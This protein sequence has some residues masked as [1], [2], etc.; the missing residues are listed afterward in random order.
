MIAELQKKAQHLLSENASAILTA[1]G[2]V[3]TVGTA[4]LTGRAS[5]KAAEI[6]HLEELDRVVEAEKVTEDDK[7]IE[8]QRLSKTEKVGL[9]WPQFLPPVGLGVATIASI[10]MANRISATRA[11]ALAAAYGV[12]Q[13]QLEEYKTKALE[14]LGVNKEQKLRDELAQDRVNENP[15]NKE[16]IIL[17]SGNVLCYDML[18]GRYFQST[19]ENIKKAENRINTVLTNTQ[20]ASLSEFYDELLPATT[21]TDNVGW[22]QIEDGMIDVKFSTVMSPN[23]EPCIAVDFNVYPHPDYTKLY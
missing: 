16:V 10:I 18:T 8:I 20:S 23:Q 14:K 22:S 5:F 19:V 7:P 6:I 4:I 11:A 21:Y 15:P 12:S 3:G 1:G 13:N 9:V 17:A 2:V